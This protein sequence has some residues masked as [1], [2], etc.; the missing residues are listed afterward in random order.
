MKN[1]ISH[2][3]LFIASSV[4]GIPVAEAIREQLSYDPLKI[5]LWSDPGIFG[6]SETAIESLEKSLE[7]FDF[8]VI[9]LTPDD[10]LRIRGEEITAPR[11]NL[12]LELGMFIGRIGRKRAFI[13]TP[14]NKKIKL[15]SDLHGVTLAYYKEVSTGDDEHDVGDACNKIRRS[16]KQAPPTTIDELIKK[17]TIP[18][19]T[20]EYCLWMYKEY[21]KTDGE[22]PVLK[23]DAQITV[24]NSR[25]K[26]IHHPSKSSIGHDV[27]IHAGQILWTTID[28][29]NEARPF[30]TILESKDKVGWIIW[31]DTGY[32]YIYPPMVARHNHR[33]VISHFIRIKNQISILEIHQELAGK[34]NKEILV[35]V[36]EILG[37][38]VNKIIQ[39]T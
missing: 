26:V 6:L 28:K 22:P 21:L 7:I 39:N 8:G 19:L 29:V 27:S 35:K 32:S 37:E 4:E 24:T 31:Y 30:K 34:F 5:R 33:I 13:V 17:L 11:D 20:I 1:K 10:I 25:G 36:G 2:P 3:T 16:I 14:K 9:V 23:V 18:E 38:R 15:P 12:I